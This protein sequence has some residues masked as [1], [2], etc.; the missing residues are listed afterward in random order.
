MT[1]PETFSSILVLAY[2]G[3]VRVAV[4]SR[5]HARGCAGSCSHEQLW[6]TGE[7][8]LLVFTLHGSADMATVSGPAC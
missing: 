2:G 8:V 6:S 3:F 4:T 5:E 7:E 1:R